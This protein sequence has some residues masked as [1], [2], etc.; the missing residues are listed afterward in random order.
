MTEVPS[1]AL[2]AAPH[3]PLT[4]YYHDEDKRAPWVRAIFDRTAVDYDRIEFLMAFGTGP[5]YRRQA[6]QRA[7]LKAGMDV[8]DVGTGTGLT[9]RAAI[10]LVGDAKR[11]LGV[12]PSPGM[13]GASLVPPESPR[14]VGS[15]EHLPVADASADFLSMGFALRHVADLDAVFAEFYR[16]LRPGARVCVL[17]IT[18]PE[19]RVARALLKF[20]LRGVVP[21]LARLF[22][23]SR[24]MPALM[25]YYWDTIEACVPP[26]AVVE[27]LAHAGFTDVTR[28]VELGMFSEYCATK[29]GPQTA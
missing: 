27:R 1:K 10:E 28:H 8:V 24:D 7:G 9:A 17:E 22:G 14:L 2:T 25:R 29:P 16:V 11:V 23:R 6:L 20:Y 21:L 12:D 18:R 19:G 3:P 13:L 26:A 15:A 5:R 4:E